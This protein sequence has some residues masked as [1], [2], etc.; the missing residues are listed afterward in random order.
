MPNWCS[1]RVEITGPADDADHLRELMTTAESSFDFNAII[2]MPVEYDNTSVSDEVRELKYGHPDWYSWALE[3]W[4]TKWNSDQAQWLST[5]EPQ[6]P[7]LVHV[8]YFDTAWGPP[9]PIIFAL[10]ERFPSLILRLSYCEPDLRFGGFVSVK[11]GEVLANR[12]T[13][14]GW[15]EVSEEDSDSAS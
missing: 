12:E 14:C 4:G 6:E 1:N 13:E 11:A 10:S 2:P 3:N 8:V 15:Q 9:F 7:D 5:A